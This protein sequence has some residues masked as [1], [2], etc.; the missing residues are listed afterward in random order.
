MPA[1]SELRVEEKVDVLEFNLQML[2]NRINTYIRPSRS[3]EATSVSDFCMVD[4][5]QS[6]IESVSKMAMAHAALES[7]MTDN[8]SEGRQSTPLS[9]PSSGRGALAVP[10]GLHTNFTDS[11]LLQFDLPP[12]SVLTRLVDAFFKHINTWAPLFTTQEVDRLLSVPWEQEEDINLLHAIVLTTI[13]HSHDPTINHDERLRYHRTSKQRL[14]A[15]VL[16]NVTL[17]SLQVIALVAVDALGDS[18]GLEG[19]RFIAL[20]VHGISSIGLDKE[21]NAYPEPLS[22]PLDGR[23]RCRLPTRPADSVEQEARRRLV[24]LTYLLDRYALLG[25]HSE[26]MLADSKMDLPIPCRYDGYCKEEII[27]TRW[28]QGSEPRLTSDPV[29]SLGS[30]ASHCELLVFLSQTH[31]F[32]EKPLDPTSSVAVQL[33]RS[34]YLALDGELNTWLSETLENASISHLC[35][36]DPAAKV[37]N[38]IMVQAA[39]I[40]STIRLH[41]TAAYPVAETGFFTASS[42][43][44][45]RCLASVES[46]RRITLDTIQTGAMKCLGYPFAFVQWTCARVLLLHA[47]TT[48]EEL[49]QTIWFFVHSLD[50]QAKHWPVASSYSGILRRILHHGERDVG[51]LLPSSGNVDIGAGHENPFMAMR[52][53]ATSPHHPALFLLPF[54]RRDIERDRR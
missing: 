27:E 41:S 52:R 13:R 9:M 15:E 8:V 38:W 34:R 31:H 19:R 25:T 30:F 20:L 6:Q 10:T 3:S 28:Y 4:K 23:S 51:E 11:L 18:D 2:T 44:R 35:H 40:L 29:G 36:P 37:S 45:G 54:S 47:A 21:K 26:F 5:P 50:T 33:W 48:G 49:N 32:I 17:R 53:Y 46:L 42:N 1:S 14:A 43:A 24:W 16:E 22:G 12:L 7:S 39:F